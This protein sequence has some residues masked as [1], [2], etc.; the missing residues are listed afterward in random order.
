MAIAMIAFPLLER[1]LR[2]VAGLAGNQPLN[3][4]FY[5]RLHHLFPEFG[6]REQARKLWAVYR[7]GLLHEVTMA[8]ISRNNAALPPAGLTHD[9]S[10]FEVDEGGVFWLHPVLFAQRVVAAIEADFSTF[11]SGVA[12]L[13]PLPHVE[14]TSFGLGTGASS[15]FPPITFTGTKGGR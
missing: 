5:E 10:L 4:R 11:D 12:A 6:T 2:Q 8:R 7:N 15:A 13:S 14:V 3:D 9:R 1:Y